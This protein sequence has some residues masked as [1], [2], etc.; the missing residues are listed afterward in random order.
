MADLYH[1]KSI[2]YEIDHLC[3]FLS[4]VLL[5]SCKKDEGRNYWGEI[6][7]LKNGEPWSG[8]IVALPNTISNLKF[9]IS[10]MTFDEEDEMV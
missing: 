4:A 2:N 8:K 6:S 1:Y 5:F 9:N 3:P 7:V 10:I